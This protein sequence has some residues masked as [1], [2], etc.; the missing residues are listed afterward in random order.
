MGNRGNPKEVIRM[1]QYGQSRTT[2][3]APFNE[4]KEIIF[5]TLPDTS[6]DGG[7][8]AFYDTITEK[9]EIHENY[10]YNQSIVSL[11]TRGTQVF[12]ALPYMQ[13]NK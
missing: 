1:D 2:A 9:I 8:L 4:G 5:G 12:G 13:I 7:A 10:I 3:V 6:V 11:I